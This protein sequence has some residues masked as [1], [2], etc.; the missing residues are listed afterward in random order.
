MNLSTVTLTGYGSMHA[1][2]VTKMV[3]A[4]PLSCINY[5]Y[6]RTTWSISKDEMCV[7]RGG[8][9]IFGCNRNVNMS[10]RVISTPGCSPN[11]S[12]TQMKHNY[13]SAFIKPTNLSP[14]PHLTLEF[15]PPF[16]PPP[17]LKCQLEIKSLIEA[18]SDHWLGCERLSLTGGNMWY[19]FKNA[20]W[21]VVFAFVL[22][23]QTQGGAAI[24]SASLSLAGWQCWFI[25]LHLFGDSLLS[26][27]SSL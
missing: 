24:C 22:V 4:S 12:P 26:E 14:C 6:G 16:P 23:S 5:V 27:F 1:Y 15:S 10:L 2:S 19:V 7:C 8:R 17:P 21:H 11:Q 9:W 13:H 20:K 18:T 3:F 25:G